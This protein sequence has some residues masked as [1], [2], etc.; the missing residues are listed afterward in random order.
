MADPIKHPM[1]VHIRHV[2]NASIKYLL[3][4]L[5]HNN[6]EIYYGYQITICL[7]CI[8]YSQPI[9]VEQFSIIQI[10]KFSYSLNILT[11]QMRNFFLL[12]L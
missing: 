10:Y 12:F 1:C 3:L 9:N 11:R 4:Q 7:V 8:N 2:I 5:V 6:Y